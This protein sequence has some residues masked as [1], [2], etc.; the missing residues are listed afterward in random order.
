MDWKVG[1]KLVCE[2]SKDSQ[3]DCQVIA[4]GSD[5][6]IVFCPSSNMVIC[7][8]QKSLERQ[9]WKPFLATKRSLS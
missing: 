3:T 8:H 1:Q 4:A 2:Q 6:I 7:G 5:G 9:G